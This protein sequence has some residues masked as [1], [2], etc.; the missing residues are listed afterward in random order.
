MSFRHEIEQRIR[1]R[2]TSIYRFLQ[3]HRARPFYGDGHG[4]VVGVTRELNKVGWWR[5]TYF[6]DGEPLG[7]VEAKTFRSAVELAVSEFG[8]DLSRVHHL[9][10]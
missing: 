2:K 5:V 9:K 3:T 8:L 7:H 1:R 6:R 10:V 4:F